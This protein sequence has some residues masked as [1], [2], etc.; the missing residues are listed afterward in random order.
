MDKISQLKKA[1]K[2]NSNLINPIFGKNIMLSLIYIFGKLERRQI[3]EIIKKIAMETNIEKEDIITHSDFII[4]LLQANHEIVN[5]NGSY[6]ITEKG[7]SEIMHYFDGKYIH[8]V[9]DKY[10]LEVL[11]LQLRKYWGVKKAT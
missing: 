1:N 5:E 3:I 6:Q 4:S 11:N 2:L 8:K 7:I 10:R 9:L